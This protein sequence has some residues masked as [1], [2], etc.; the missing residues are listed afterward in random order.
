MWRR[1]GPCAPR[2]RL[3]AQGSRAM[4][5]CRCRTWRRRRTDTHPSAAS[6]PAVSPAP[7]TPA[8]RPA[9]TR[10]L[11]SLPSTGSDASSPGPGSSSRDSLRLEESGP[12]YTGPFCGRARVHTDFTPS[13]Y[14]KDSLKLRVRHGHGRP[15]AGMKG[16]PRVQGGRVAGD[17]PWAPVPTSVPISLAPE[18]G[19]HRHHREAAHGHLDRAAQQ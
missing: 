1:R 19:H 18:R 13:P 3:A 15:G 16:T 11:T 2:P 17:P 10:V 7:V 12:A 8:P 9:A 6:C 5:R 14:D 4:R